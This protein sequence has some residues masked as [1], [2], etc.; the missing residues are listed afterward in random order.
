MKRVFGSLLAMLVLMAAAPGTRLRPTRPPRAPAFLEPIGWP[1][2]CGTLSMSGTPTG[3]SSINILTAPRLMLAWSTGVNGPIASAPSVFRNTLY[4]GDWGGYETAIETENGKVVARANLGMTNAPQ[5]DPSTLGVTSSPAIA[6]GV[7]YL[8][9]GDD[10]FYALDAGDL[11]VIWKKTMGD[12][13]ASGGYYGWSS[14]AVVGE[15]VIQGVSSNCDNPFVP[16]R[17]VAIDRNTGNE[18]ASASFIGDGKIGNGVWTSPTVNLRNRKIFVTTASGLDFSDGL[19]YSIVRLNLDTLAI[20]DSWKVGAA[21]STWD[22]DWGS[23]PTLFS[24]RTGRQL[25]GAGHKDGHYYAFDQ[26]NLAQGPVWTATVAQMGEVPQSGDGTLS[27]A[28]FDGARLY[29]GGGTPADTNDA[30]AHGTVVAVDPAKGS[31]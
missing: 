24:D 31:I 3:G 7:I 12:N 22:A 26:T 28:A 5:C 19:G 11:S 21:D 17:L 18:V 29:V 15:R 16:G 13:S 9:G 1:K 6:D 10:S 8:A 23:S 30:Y 14:P 27:T 2:Y 25:V 20:E 4:V